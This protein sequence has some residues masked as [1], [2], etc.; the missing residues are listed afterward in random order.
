MKIKIYLLIVLFAAAFKN[1]YA[2]VNK[3]LSTPTYPT[4]SNQTSL[5]D[6]NNS[7]NLNSS[8]LAWRNVYFINCL[9]L[10]NRPIF[11][12]NYNTCHF[13]EDK[14]ATF[15]NFADT[16]SFVLWQNSDENFKLKSQSMQTEITNEDEAMRQLLFHY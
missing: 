4:S 7:K 8:S 11:Q 3:N 12:G 2:Q 10:L 16:I 6:T 5:P 15:N 14:L 1:S 13:N 9:H